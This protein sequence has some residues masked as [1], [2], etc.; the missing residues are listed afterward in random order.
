MKQ[1]SKQMVIGLLIA[2]GV[3]AQALI[4]TQRHQALLNNPLCNQEC[5]GYCLEYFPV[6]NS[7]SKCGCNN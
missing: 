5:L 1:L 3:N 2:H 6:E 7:L 4:G